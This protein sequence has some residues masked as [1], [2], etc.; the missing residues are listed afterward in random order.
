[1]TQAESTTATGELQFDKDLEPLPGSTDRTLPCP[2]CNKPVL[3]NEGGIPYPH[4]VEI[5]GVSL[6]CTADPR[7]QTVQCTKCHTYIRPRASHMCGHMLQ[8]ATCPED[9]DQ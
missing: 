6:P 2:R 9:H 5:R 3:H 7:D 4:E 1:M 8:C